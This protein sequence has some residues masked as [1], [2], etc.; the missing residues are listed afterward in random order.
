MAGL[1]HFARNVDA[2]T[3][4]ETLQT[5][6]ALIL[7]DFVSADFIDALRAETDPYME[8]TINGQDDF[9]GRKTTRTGGLMI[10][11]EKCRELIADP[12]ILAA[13]NAF[14]SPFCERVQLHLTQIIRIRGGE[15]A[16][17]IH[18]DRW[19][20]GKHL[21]HVE[22]QFNTIWA[23]TDFTAENG[24][25]QVVPGSTQWPDDAEIKAEQIT[26]A[27]MKAGS[28]LIYSGSVFHGGGANN[29][30]GDRIGI[31]ITYTLGWLR[32]EENQYLTCP[33]ELAKDLSRT[34]QELAGYAM[35]QYALG[36]Y[37]P[38]GA[39]GEEPEIVPPQYA[40]GVRK[41]LSSMGETGDLAALQKA[42]KT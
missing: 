31:N 2:Q 4:V 16:Q 32:Q 21:A 19:A 40:L 18:R 25:T 1:K 8:A 22:P 17:A 26:Q 10:R 37:T 5:D 23:L 3:I 30:D 9:S 27:E 11:S 13:C 29:S 20:W 7:D 12:H 41:D 38:P 36:Y 39:P 14:L 24:A 33:P 6:G 15:R 35:G 28:V 34:L 42:L